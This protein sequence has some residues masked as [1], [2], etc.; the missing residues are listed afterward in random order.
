[1][2]KLV[3]DEVVPTGCDYVA[4]GETADDVV[5]KMSEHGKEVHADIG[6]DMTD[7]EHK[8]MGEKMYSL[9]KDA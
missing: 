1:M 3:C 5:N 8:A 2:K 7:E 6:K 4:E 9:V